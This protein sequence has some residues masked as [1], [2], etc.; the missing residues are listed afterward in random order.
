VEA[1]SRARGQRTWDEWAAALRRFHEFSQE[2]GS[3][4][5]PDAPGVE[6]QFVAWLAGTRTPATASKIAGSLRAAWA[7]L[8]TSPEERVL[9]DLVR[10]GM[11]AA[12]PAVRSAPEGVPIAR[13]LKG[14]TLMPIGTPLARRDKAMV[15]CALLMGTRPRDLTCMVRGNDEFLHL[16]DSGAARV[17]FRADKGSRLTGV[18]ASAVVLIPHVEEFPIAEILQDVMQD[19]AE[20]ELQRVDGQYPLFV[21]LSGSRRGTQLSVDTVSNVLGRFLET[22]GLSGR[23][24]EA[25][26]IRAYVASSAYELGVDPQD[27][28]DH[29]RWRSVDTFRQHYRRHAV[30]RQLVGQP[31]S[32]RHG[33]SVV[34]AFALAFRQSAV[35]DHGTHPPS[36]VPRL[37]HPR[38]GTGSER[39]FNAATPSDAERSGASD[40][41]APLERASQSRGRGDP[42]TLHA[43]AV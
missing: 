43:P 16:A 8:R 28:C 41:V 38:P 37:V 15:L 20:T 39:S 2:Q 17:R 3:T 25:R 7:V 23:A 18:A 1:L 35:T 42:P 21:T 32:G 36:F 22:V 14:W 6:L 33:S 11:R 13:L 24:A 12:M 30:E 40:G 4:P 9:E 27:L 5:D 19:I 31:L 26:Q 10:R 29:F 34:H